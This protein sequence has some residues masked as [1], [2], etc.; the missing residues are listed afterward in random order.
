MKYIFLFYF[1]QLDF[2]SSLYRLYVFISSPFTY[3]VY[4]K[5]SLQD[6]LWDDSKETPSSMISDGTSRIFT[7]S[8]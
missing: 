8:V 5:A 7:A 4:T 6:L 3:F 2:L 1:E